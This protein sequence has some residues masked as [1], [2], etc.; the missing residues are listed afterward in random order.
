MHRGDLPA[1]QS[2]VPRKPQDVLR[3]V[4]RIADPVFAVMTEMF[5]L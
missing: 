5:C 2:R 1:T 4:T 3:Y